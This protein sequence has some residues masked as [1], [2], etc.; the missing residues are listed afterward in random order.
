MA[1]PT[2][3]PEQQKTAETAIENDGDANW[4]AMLDS[5]EDDGRRCWILLKT[6]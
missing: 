4:E 6:I 5:S 1:D 2:E 3:T